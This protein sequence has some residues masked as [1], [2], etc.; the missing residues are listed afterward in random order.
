MRS[1]LWVVVW[2]ALAAGATS[3][4]AQQGGGTPLPF[5]GAAVH[6]GVDSCGGSSCHG[7]LEPWSG[8]TVQQ[9]EFVTWQEKDPHAKAY[10]TLMSEA[11]KRIAANLG[12]ANAY[13]A[14]I[15]LDCH[16]DN[17]KGPQRA[18]G[19]Q[20]SD[21]VGCES[22]HGGAEQWLGI[23]ISGRAD[24]TENI[25]AGLFP[26]ENPE[27]RARL[28]LSC[29]FGDKDRI[30]T[31]RIMGAGHPRMGFELDTYTM[32]QPAHFKLDAD[33]AKRKGQVDHFKIWAIGQVVAVE[34][35]LD[36]MLDPKRNQDGIFPELVFF[37][38]HACHHP[39]SNVRWEP[40][41]STGI[42]PGIPRLNDANILMMAALLD[43]VDP[44]LAQDARNRSRALHQAS[45][46]GRE[47]TL[48]AAKALR[49]LTTPLI[50]KISSRNF[51][52][53]EMRA[54]M[55]GVIARGLKGD[56][57]DYAGAEQA[58]M[59]LSAILDAMRTTGALS[60]GQYKD[61]TKLL[62]QAYK[63]IEKDEA[64]SPRQFLA[65][66]QTFEAA[67]PRS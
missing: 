44:A 26:T 39:M 43:Q 61:L 11:S 33:Y 37:D 32:T 2:T 12:L 42:S 28:C 10:K 21:G 65:A 18:K 1:V 20:L 59:A 24:H 23:H 15:C 34:S 48:A 35:L 8:S 5:A 22:C 50:A 67:V 36:A 4:S 66:L 13:E 25:K 49:D 27:A 52:A 30:I 63:A 7:A 17:V 57:I 54:T 58:T 3:V 55:S 38:C 16:A 29:H 60:D 62:D 51:G 9:N 45:L 41:E 56:F 19:F 46:K 14:D 31:H 40:R 53:T 64:Y 6:L 47:A